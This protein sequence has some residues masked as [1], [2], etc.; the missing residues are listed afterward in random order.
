MIAESGGPILRFVFTPRSRTELI[1]KLVYALSFCNWSITTIA[2]GYQ[3]LG[4][5]PQTLGVYVDIVNDTDATKVKVQF[6]GS[7]TGYAH[8]LKYN[9]AY[10]YQIICGPCQLFISRVV[11]RS[12]A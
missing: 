7:S 2:G 11:V 3:C 6:H 10:Q 4:I 9:S 5:S 1:T 12:D 8:L